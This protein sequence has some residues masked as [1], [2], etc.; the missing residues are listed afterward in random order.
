[1]HFFATFSILSH[2]AVFKRQD[3]ELFMEQSI[4]LRTALTGGEFIVTHLDDRH[5]SIKIE[6]GEVIKPG[7]FFLLIL[8]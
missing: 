7:F 6:P 5:L 1:V 2:P 8:D 4:D 3:K